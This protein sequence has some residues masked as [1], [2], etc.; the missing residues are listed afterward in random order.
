MLGGQIR[1]NCA[2]RMKP[3]QATLADPD[4]TA[5]LARSTHLL[6]PAGEFLELHLLLPLKVVSA[7]AVHGLKGGVLRRGSAARTSEGGCV[8]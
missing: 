4:H 6:P 5:K 1:I 2:G 3:R 8:D 7:L